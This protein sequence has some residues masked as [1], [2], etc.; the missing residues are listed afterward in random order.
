MALI[1]ADIVFVDVQYLSMA[2]QLWWR[3]D[4]DQMVINSSWIKRY[5]YT[6]VSNN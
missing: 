6:W 1:L 5:K 3:F 2:G 4:G